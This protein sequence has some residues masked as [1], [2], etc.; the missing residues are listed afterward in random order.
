MIMRWF[1]KQPVVPHFQAYIPGCL[2]VHRFDHRSIQQSFSTNKF[3][4][5]RVDLAELI[6]EN[7]AQAQLA[8]AEQQKKQTIVEA[9]AQLE[10]ARRQ[11]EQRVVMAEAEAKQV[12]IAAEAALKKLGKTAP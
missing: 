10:Q 2:S 8:K 1:G 7:D 3:D 12:R 4:V 9:E 5:R 6:T 11:A